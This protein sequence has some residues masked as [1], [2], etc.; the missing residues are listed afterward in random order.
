[1]PMF[2]LHFEFMFVHI[3]SVV[4][5]AVNLVEIVNGHG[6]SAEEST[7]IINQMMIHSHTKTKALGHG[8]SVVP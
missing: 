5:K 3:S 2:V 4:N 7:I 1:M 8:M 6:M